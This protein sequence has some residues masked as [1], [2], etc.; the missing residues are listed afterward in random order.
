MV[1]DE[2]IIQTG[3]IAFA[4][5]SL[6]VGLMIRFGGPHGC[7]NLTLIL[8]VVMAGASVFCLHVISS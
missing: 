6:Q 3:A 7:Q 1:M 4:L 8:L 2:N 5:A